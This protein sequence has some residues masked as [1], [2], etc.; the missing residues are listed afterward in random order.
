MYRFILKCN[1]LNSWYFFE[2]ISSSAY[3]YVHIEYLRVCVCSL[4][5]VPPCGCASCVISAQTS[6]SW[7]Y[8]PEQ[9]F[10]FLVLT[11]VASS[12]V[13]TSFPVS[14]LR[15]SHTTVSGPRN[16]KSITTPNKESR[17]GQKLKGLWKIVQLFDLWF[18][19][20]KISF[21]VHSITCR[22]TWTH[23]SQH[24]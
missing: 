19:S 2:E 22:K 18:N 15:Q 23:Y 14:V 16:W 3:L 21:S 1:T 5:V 24:I 4:S 11:I 9:S 7:A 10:R 6:S 17:P 8:R 12:W 13:I 20:P